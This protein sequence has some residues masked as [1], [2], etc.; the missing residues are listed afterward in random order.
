[1]TPKL[2]P[3]RHHP[4]LLALLLIAGLSFCSGFLAVGPPIHHVVGAKLLQEQQQHAPAIIISRHSFSLRKSKDDNSEED[5]KDSPIN[6]EQE[7]KR[8]ESLL[9]GDQDNN[10]S[11][12]STSSS[13]SSGGGATTTEFSSDIFLK[14]PFQEWQD[15]LSKLSPPPLTSIGRERMETEITL[16]ESLTSSDDGLAELWNLWYNARGPQA[17]KDLMATESLVAMGQAAGWKQAEERLRT[18]VAKEGLY[19]VEPINRLAT[20]LFLQSRLEESLA[21]C[22]LVIKLKPWHFGA[23]SGIV[24]VHQGLQ[25]NRKMLEWAAKRMPPLPQNKQEEV[26]QEE[27][28]LQMGIETRQT[29][30]YRMVDKAT[31][32][33]L[34]EEMGLEEGFTDLDKK[35]GTLQPQ[36]DASE[37][38]T[39]EASSS[40][41][42]NNTIVSGDEEDG[43]AWQ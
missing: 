25:D 3:F 13:S 22:E 2:P 15:Q 7:R 18:I 26:Q 27:Q 35:E 6:L 29:W 11:S 40:I 14:L 5:E 33:L 38:T 10:K 43:D 20:L 9:M 39:K 24:M 16:L 36:K 19:F 41:P 21:L 4:S 1:M 34:R 28:Q 37:K 32:A 23:L 17:A 30:V 12:T 42:K 8:L 31:A